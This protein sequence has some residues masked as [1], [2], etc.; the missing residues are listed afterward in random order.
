MERDGNFGI[1][2]RSLKN[3]LGE[4]VAIPA[5]APDEHRRRKRID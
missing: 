4:K 2:L 5:C 1:G 3:L